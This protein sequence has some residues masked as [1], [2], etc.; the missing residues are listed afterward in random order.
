M[1]KC[2]A[3]VA[4][5]LT[6]AVLLSSL[7][8]SASAS[9]F[10]DKVG[11]FLMTK[12]LT[13][14]V[15]EKIL[16]GV[17][18][19]LDLIVPERGS[20]PKWD[21][22]YQVSNFLPGD[23]QFIDENP[24]GTFS[25]GTAEASLVPENWKEMNVHLGGF[26]G[27]EN[28]FCN[29]MEEATDD[30]R[31]RVFALD[32]G[33]GRGAAVVAVVDSIGITNKTIREIRGKVLESIGESM[34]VK[35]ITISATHCHSC[36]D[37]EGLWSELLPK[38]CKNL[39][40]LWTGIGKPET[41]T[42]PEYMAFFKDTVADTIVK[43]CRDLTPG[44]L[45]FAQ[46]KLGDGFL[47]FK[48]AETE[49]SLDDTLSRLVFT[50]N[51]TNKKP[52]MIVTMAAHPDNAGLPTGSN[53]GRA[54]SGDYVYYMGEAV[55]NAGY[56]FVFF[57]G[58]IASIYFDSGITNNDQENAR[59][60]D[61]SVRYGRAIG[62]M[63]VAMTMTEAEILANPNL[64][65]A[66]VEAEEL[67]VLAEHNK[68]RSEADQREYW[69]WYKGWEPVQETVVDPVLNVKHQQIFVPVTNSLLRAVCKLHLVEYDVVKKDKTY[70]AVT[71][72]GYMEL[73]GGQVKIAM[74]PGEVIQDLVY[75]GN[76]L[77]AEGS[78][79]GK[80]FPYPTV[81][82]LFGEDV[83]AIG[84]ANDAVGYILP[85]TN[86]CMSATRYNEIISLGSK[87]ASTMILGLQEIAESIK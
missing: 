22:N 15:Q 41:G 75:G 5:V 55:N 39:L 20:V 25:L 80:A 49:S 68:N 46:K 42:I 51:D 2:K 23:E 4:A 78:V 27:I 48:N 33:T 10:G 16:T 35:S 50:P 8:V 14:K 70:Y 66:K 52:T 63:A 47:R 84:L 86:Y 12:V 30:M 59:R 56:N 31:V 11:D 74:L 62:K 83:I 6:I 43:A 32:D 13:D 65:D 64:Y 44:T 87:T 60:V 58:A 85:D 7:T 53:S 24:N 34:K 17:V 45:T 40:K 9:S 38:L 28:G 69:Y 26:M 76:S 71:E 81:A 77:T 79:L 73:G 54:L 36:I 18:R 21:D 3:I 67:A 37:T 1:K 57:N 19:G 72:V 29:K 82:D 61:S